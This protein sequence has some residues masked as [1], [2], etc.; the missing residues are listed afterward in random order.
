ME[1]FLAAAD[2]KIT[3]PKLRVVV[4]VTIVSQ[5]ASLHSIVFATIPSYSKGAIYVPNITYKISKK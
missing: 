1:E 5:V 3:H 4:G 2:R